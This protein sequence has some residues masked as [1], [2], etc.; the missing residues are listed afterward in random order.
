MS[1]SSSDPAPVPALWLDD[2]RHVA[3]PATEWLWPGYVAPGNLTLLTSQWKAGKT[4]LLSL[5]LDRM[6]AGGEL[7]GLPVKPG[8]ALVVSEESHQVWLDR[9]RLYDFAGH[10]CWLCRPFSTRPD[11]PQWLALVDQML[12]L[13]ARFGFAVVAIDPLASLFPRHSEHSAD[14]MLEALMPLQRLTS[15]GVAVKLLHHPRKRGG[16][17]GQ[18]SRGHGV[19]L[20]HAD[21]LLEMHWF[22]SAAAVDRR[23]RLL[24]WSR[25]VETPRQRVIELSA[26]GRAY[27]CLGDFDEEADRPLQLLLWQVFERA[28]TKLTCTQI[29]ECWPPDHAKPPQTTLWRVLGQ[30]VERGRLKRDATGVRGDPHRFWLPALEDRWKTDVFA[31]MQQEVADARRNVQSKIPGGLLG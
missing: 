6:K 16:L 23:R 8:K 24:G 19:L 15:A 9:S 7:A 4:T 3:L 13:H 29:L 31:R 20:S 27:V 2:L 1:T 26:D 22:E 5:F 10:V 12:A 21:I 28:L 14:A 18:A 17:D 25:H 30:A 11:L